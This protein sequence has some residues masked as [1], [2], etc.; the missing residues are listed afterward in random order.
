MNSFAKAL[1]RSF[2]RR[3]YRVTVCDRVEALATLLE[4]EPMQYAVVDLKLSGASGL[5]CVKMLY[6]RNP[7]HAGSSC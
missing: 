4:S 2:E 7:D 5:E 6:A 3:G 1:R